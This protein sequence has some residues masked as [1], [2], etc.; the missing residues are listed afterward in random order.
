MNKQQ[1]LGILDLPVGYTPE[2]LRKKYRKMSAR[3]HPDIAGD[4]AKDRFIEINKAYTFLT[5]SAKNKAKTLF[6]HQSIFTVT[7]VD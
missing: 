6:T 5:G 4:G 1:A 7:T 3:Y 2:E